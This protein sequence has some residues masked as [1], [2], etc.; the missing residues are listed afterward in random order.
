M[1]KSLSI[2]CA[3]VMLTITTCNACVSVKAANFYCKKI[4]MKFQHDDSWLFRLFVIKRNTIRIDWICE[5]GCVLVET[6]YFPSCY[7]PKDLQNNEQTEGHRS[8]MS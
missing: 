7:T 3:C 2:R 8:E 1:T 6:P 5:R 4:D